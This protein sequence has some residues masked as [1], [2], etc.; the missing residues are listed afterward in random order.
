MKRLLIPIL[1]AAVSWSIPAFAQPSFDDVLRAID[2]VPERASLEQAFPD[3]RDRLEAAA[4]D[5]SRSTYERH[6]AVTL[7]LQYPDARTRAYLAALS[8][9]STQPAEV[10][11]MAVYT[12][13]RTFGDSSVPDVVRFVA[14]F[15]NDEPVVAQWAVRALRWVEH[16]EAAEILNRVAKT[17]PELEVVARRAL[18]KRPASGVASDRAP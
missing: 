7:L 4:R 1:I 5:G 13:G 16:P 12:Y 18:R 2:V 10:R 14:S 8:K 17:R 15:L 11:K 3:V 9:D 6:R